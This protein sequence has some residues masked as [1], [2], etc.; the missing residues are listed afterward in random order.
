MKTCTT[1]RGQWHLPGIPVLLCA[2]IVSIGALSKSHALEI[3]DH[4][5]T[6]Y[7]QGRG[8]GIGVTS[9]GS[10]ILISSPIDTSG[11]AELTF[12]SFVPGFRHIPRQN[13]PFSPNSNP[14]LPGE[15]TDVAALLSGGF[16]IA[17]V[18]SD[19]NSPVNALISLK[20]GTVINQYP[21]PAQPDG[22]EVTPDGTY[23]IVAVEKGG[24]IRIYDLSR[25]PE[26][27]TLVAVVTRAALVA[28]FQN[29]PERAGV[30]Y[31]NVEP[32]AVG[33]AAD[34]S[35]ALVT[36]QDAA[37]VAI[38]DLAAMS[39]A[40]E[41]GGLTPD[42]VGDRTLKNVVHLP[43]GIKGSNGALFGVEPDGV[44][45]S[46]D[47]DFA[48][49]ALEAN[50][51]AKHIQGIAV[52]DLRNGLTGNIPTTSY[53]IFGVDPSLL[54]NT[55]LTEAPD[56]SA[57][58]YPSDANKLPRL[59]P[60]GI[61]MVKFEQTV[62]APLVIER[63]DPSAAQVTASTTN[64]VR[65]SVL[66]LDVTNVLSTGLT[67]ANVLKRLRIGEPG[68]RLEGIDTAQHGRWIFVSISNGGGTK[69]SAVRLEIIKDEEASTP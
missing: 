32:E 12:S 31:A 5:Q 2:A 67:P 28:Y 8:E 27:I 57:T 17:V 6:I 53:S 56:A 10:R 62:V 52:L 25:G 50:Q 36:I 48:L 63:Y 21:I 14:A 46:P 47:G 29:M 30:D 1:A 4:V 24:E 60:A 45:I 41:E 59:D 11:G 18:R 61:K 42:Q 68:S 69:G 39:Q 51:R 55:G 34:S 35:F 16:D 44:A 13:D 38:I 9:N 19:S 49:L 65:G 20:D 3:S 37:S 43:F 64:E 58:F 23:A 26:A 54:A 66:F 33:I 7:A 40:I 22:M 15:V